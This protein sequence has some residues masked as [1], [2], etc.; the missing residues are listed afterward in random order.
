MDDPWKGKMLRS[1]KE[2]DE[3]IDLASDGEFDSKYS[4]MTYEQ[5]V[6]AAIDWILGKEDEP[7][8]GQ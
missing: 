6:L 3:Q 1:Q 8:M 7:P 2:I 4:G 5:G